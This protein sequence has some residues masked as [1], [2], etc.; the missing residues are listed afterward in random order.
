VHAI[1]YWHTESFFLLPLLCINEV[2]NVC[3]TNIEAC[4]GFFIQVRA[5]N[6]YCPKFL[7]LVHTKYSV[8]FVYSQFMIICVRPVSGNVSNVLINVRASFVN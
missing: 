6:S 3:V 5:L 1:I 7:G 8:I 4:L 2:G